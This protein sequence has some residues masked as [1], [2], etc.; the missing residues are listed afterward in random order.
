M[1][2]GR[3]PGPRGG[4]IWGSLPAFKADPIGLLSQAVREHGDVVRLRFGPVIAH[5]INHPDHIEQVLSRRSASYDKRT[6]SVA[7]I[8]ATCGDSLLSSDGPTWQRHRRLIQ[9]VFQPSYLQSI[10]PIVDAAMA[11]LLDRWTGIARKRGRVDIVSEMMHLVIFTSARILFSSDV[12]ADRIERALE[13]ILQDTWRRLQVPL[14]PSMLSPRLH[15]RAYRNAVAEIDGIVFQLI[16]DRRRSNSI[17][18][19]LLSRLLGAHEDESEAPLTDQELRDAAVTLL[20]AGH[21]STANALAWAFYN[22]AQSP[23]RGLESA[24]PHKLFAETLR[25]YPSIWILERRVVK[26]DRIGPYDL[27][28]G[29]TVLISPYLLHR[30]KTYWPN[31]DHFDPERFQPDQVDARPRN[32]YLPFGLGPH[33]CIGLHMANAIAPRVLSNVYDQ[34]RLSLVP[35]Q[36]AGMMPGITLRHPDALWM[37]VEQNI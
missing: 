35:G 11:P 32:A 3:A 4:L 5:L 26:S 30:N 36:A 21:E 10:G 31:P 34:F 8:R 9:P 19:D 25:L 15:R 27:R 20:L 1:S 17:N 18:D 2:G 24:D 16:R 22:V 7:Q 13:V 12:D 28:K 29:T 37:A 23:D 33:R 14:D 6:R